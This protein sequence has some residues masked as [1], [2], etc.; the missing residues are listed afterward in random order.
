MSVTNGTKGAAEA[1]VALE[2]P[3]GWKATPASVPIHFAHEDES[4]SARFQSRAAAGEDRRVHPARRGDL[5]GH[6]RPKVHQRLPGD[7]ISARPAPPGDQAGRD[8]PQS[9]RREDRAEPVGGLHRGCGRPGA[10]GH[11]AIGREAHL[12]RP[13]RTGLGRPL[14]VR[15]D[16]DRRPRLRAARRPARLQSPPAGLRRARRHGHRAVQQD[17]VQPGGVRPVSR[18]R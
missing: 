10:A 7:R 15:R 3:A 17:G 1:T 13:G 4:L 16:R 8:H 14:E 9:G 5:A 11:R 12:H 18:P 6:R 2:L